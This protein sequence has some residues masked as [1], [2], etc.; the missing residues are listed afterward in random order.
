MPKIGLTKFAPPQGAF[1]LYI[2]VSEYTN[3]SKVFVKEM[4]SQ[5]NVACVSGIDF[6]QNHGN[7]HVRFSYA[8]KYKDI[9]KAVE[10]IRLWLKNNY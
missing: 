5:A 7:K 10:Q 2:D 1:Y 3:N 8:C 4:L 6:D 9:I